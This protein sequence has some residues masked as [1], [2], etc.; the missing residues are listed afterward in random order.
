MGTRSLLPSRARRQTLIAYS[1][2]ALALA[3]RRASQM[4]LSAGRIS[5]RRVARSCVP[6]RIV[7]RYSF[8]AWSM[9]CDRMLM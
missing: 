3:R 5:P 1:G 8:S 7:G 4:I 9:I 6:G 2:F